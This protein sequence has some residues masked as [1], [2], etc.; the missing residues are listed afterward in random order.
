MRTL[1][2]YNRMSSIGIHIL[3]I[4]GGGVIEG[5]SAYDICSPI[6]RLVIETIF[7]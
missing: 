4:C 1:T 7:K 2:S 5:Y 3:V 6:M